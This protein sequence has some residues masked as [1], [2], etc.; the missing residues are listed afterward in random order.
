MLL[1]QLW[2]G[3][4][5]LTVL[6]SQYQAKFDGLIMIEVLVQAIL[7]QIEQPKKDLEHNL[8]ALL[9]EAVSKMDLVSKE[10]IQR[11]QSML[12]NA[13]LRLSQLQEQLQAL[14]TELQRQSTT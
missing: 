6:H 10:E 12:D 4:P 13:N 3:T 2:L 1:N 7:E 5:I 9:S 11:Q 8:H 14:E